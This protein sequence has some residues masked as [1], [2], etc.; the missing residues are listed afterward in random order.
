MASNALVDIFKIKD[1][2]D[3]ILFTVLVLVIF[4]L[5]VF[6]PIPGID[7]NV[8]MSYYASQSGS[9]FDFLDFFVGGAFSNVSIFML[10]IMPYITT[11][12]IMQLLT[13]IFPKLKKK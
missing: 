2:R 10:G 7:R 12:I 6:I 1:L 3:R 13:I 4:R 5:G 8:V 9:M 11:S